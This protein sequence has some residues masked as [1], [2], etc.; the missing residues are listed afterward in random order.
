MD[1][2]YPTIQSLMLRIDGLEYAE[3]VRSNAPDA[4]KM[5]D[6]IKRLEQ[7]TIRLAYHNGVQQSIIQLLANRLT[8]VGKLSVEARHHIQSITDKYSTGWHYYGARP[9]EFESE[10]DSLRKIM[11]V[12]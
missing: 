8:E 3:R 1:E 10:L 6:D 5:N 7:D 2:I 9:F 12:G 11:P 4:I